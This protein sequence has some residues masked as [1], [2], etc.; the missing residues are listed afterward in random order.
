MTLSGVTKKLFLDKS[1]SVCKV[2]WSEVAQ[3]C[4][5]LCGP[6]DCRPPGSSV[7]GILQT[8][9]LEWVA[10]SFSRG[11][12]LSSV[13]PAALRQ[14]EEK[15]HWMW[16]NK[17]QTFEITG[18]EGLKKV[19][20]GGFLIH[21]WDEIICFSKLDTN[22]LLYV[23]LAALGLSCGTQALLCGMRVSL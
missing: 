7:Y 22:I 6:V 19:S 23:C 14:G 1:T 8:R 3:S 11:S 20:V 9:I 12:S 2:K 17:V 5:T 13:P 16:L 4:R 15:T 10:I 18:V 21:Q